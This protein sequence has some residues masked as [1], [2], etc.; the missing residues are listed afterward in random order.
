[1]LAGVKTGPKRDLQLQGL[2]PGPVHFLHIPGAIAFCRQVRL[3]CLVHHRDE[4]NDEGPKMVSV[5]FGESDLLTTFPKVVLLIALFPVNIQM[6][7]H[8]ELMPSLP[9]WT[10]WARLPLQAVLIAWAYWFTA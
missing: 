10:L 2:A 1:V 7:L 9:A 8:P 4:S 5:N 3:D 6:A